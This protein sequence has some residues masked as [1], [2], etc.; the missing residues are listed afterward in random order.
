MN[1]FDAAAVSMSNAFVNVPDTTPFDVLPN[2]IPL[3][4]MN[5]PVASLHGLQKELAVASMMMDF[6]EPD[7]APEDLLNRAIWHS[8]KGYGTP[9][10][11]IQTTSCL[12]V[13]RKPRAARV[14]N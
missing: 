3:D 13:L 2:Q 8:V 11:N 9:Y 10:P 4:E 7:A 1:Q 6:S 14:V 12:P 5:P